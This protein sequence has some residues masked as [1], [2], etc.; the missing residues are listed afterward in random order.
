[1][2]VKMKDGRVRSPL[3]VRDNRLEHRLCVGRFVGYSKTK[4]RIVCWSHANFLFRYGARKSAAFIF[5]GANEKA[6]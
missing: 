6:L 5:L 3:T 4:H 2:C 1:M